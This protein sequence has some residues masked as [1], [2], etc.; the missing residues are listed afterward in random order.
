MYYII[1]KIVSL[2]I[3]VLFWPEIFYFAV[4]SQHQYDVY[5]ID[6]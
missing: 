2:F 6:L 1:V 5:I 4:T 3:K